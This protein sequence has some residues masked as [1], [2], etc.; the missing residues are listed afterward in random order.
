MRY[1]LIKSRTEDAREQAAADPDAAIADR[2]RS[3][4]EDQV[5]A[6]RTEIDRKKAKRRLMVFL[7]T[8]A[9][10]SGPRKEEAAQD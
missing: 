2:A 7:R 6:A 8:R 5:K 1:L 3:A 9:A 4:L 10:D